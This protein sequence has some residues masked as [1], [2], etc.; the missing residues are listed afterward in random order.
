MYEYKVRREKGKEIIG[1][2]KI[3]IFEFY[4]SSLTHIKIINNCNSFLKIKK[5]LINTTF[6][7]STFF[8]FHI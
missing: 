6:Q 2:L 8:Q 5:I 1:I 7:I 4:F 3:D